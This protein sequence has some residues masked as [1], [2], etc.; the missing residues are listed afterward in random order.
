MARREPLP[1]DPIAEA[2]RQWIAH[3]WEDAA[4]G[5]AAVTS[6]MRAHQLMLARVDA[7][8][9]PFRLS[10]ARYEMLRLLAFTRDG[11]LPMSSATAR[12]QVHPASVTSTVD[13]L[14]RDGL[15]LR[16]PHPHDGRATILVLTDAGRSIVE[17][18]TESLNTEVFADPGIDEA[19]VSALVHAVARLRQGAGDFA[20]PRV[21]PEPL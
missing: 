16:A 13:R 19:N 1:V 18:A 6:I 10:F 21:M 5:M 11:H 2:R 14:E 17:E 7:A 15:A 8:L 3:G 4:D 9:K 12:L 20:E